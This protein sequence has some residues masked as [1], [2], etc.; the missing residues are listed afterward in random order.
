MKSSPFLIKNAIFSYKGEERFWLFFQ[1]RSNQ[2]LKTTLLFGQGKFHGKKYQLS[3]RIGVA[4]IQI[5]AM[6]RSLLSSTEA[7]LSWGFP[8]AASKPGIQILLEQAK[9]WSQDG[10]QVAMVPP[11]Q[12]LLEMC[13]LELVG[14]S[15]SIYQAVYPQR[16]AASKPPERCARGSSGWWVVLAIVTFRCWALEQQAVMQFSGTETTCVT[17]TKRWGCHM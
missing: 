8:P 17:G 4:Q 2:A 3:Q 16:P 14:K 1:W 6:R 10:R 12:N 5:G 15:P 7:E 11:W 13:P 9:P